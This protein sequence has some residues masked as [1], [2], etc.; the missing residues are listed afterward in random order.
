MPLTA[1]TRS[2]WPLWTGRWTKWWTT[3]QRWGKQ[4]VICGHPGDAERILEKVAFASCARFQWGIEISHV[5]S[6]GDLAQESNP[7]HAGIG[8]PKRVR[9]VRHRWLVLKNR[10]PSNRGTQGTRNLRGPSTSYV[11]GPLPLSCLPASPVHQVVGRPGVDYPLD[12]DA[13]LRG[14]LAPVGL[15]V[16]LTGR[17]GVGV[18]REHASG[19]DGQPE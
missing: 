6:D 14:S 17:V 10:A 3:R 2:W 18:D 13:A 19:L 9:I 15:P 12:R 1:E 5:A 11:E 7:G 8:K 16:E 4:R